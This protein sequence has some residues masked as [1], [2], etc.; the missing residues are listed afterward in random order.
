MFQKMKLLFMGAAI[1]SLGSVH[2]SNF[3]FIGAGAR[4]SG[5]GGA[6][7]AVANDATSIFWNPGGLTHLYEPELS[8][9]GRMDGSSFK[10]PT[11][12]AILTPDAFTGLSVNFAS[13]AYSFKAIGN[14][15]V[16]IAAS[17]S[18]LYDF[19]ANTKLLNNDGSLYLRTDRGKLSQFAVGGAIDVVPG[20]F[21]GTA[22]YWHRGVISIDEKNQG[23]TG[24]TAKT[25][26]SLE[27]NPMLG[28][29]FYWDLSAKWHFGAMGSFRLGALDVI[30]TSGGVPTSSTLG[31]PGSVGVGAAWNPTETI[32]VAMDYRLIQWSGLE[33]NGSRPFY[34]AALTKPE[35]ADAAQLHLGAEYFFPKSPFND[36]PWPWRVGLYTDPS[37]PRSSTGV[38]TNVTFLTIGTSFLTDFGDISM[39]GEFGTRDYGLGI[40]E[41]ATRFIVSVIYRL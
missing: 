9:V 6:F 30:T 12:A 22:L 5:M 29:G 11:A 35:F 16:A 23:A 4:A 26:I 40:E 19:D 18:S 37:G 24:V 1:L 15:H 17:F 10:F 3:G 31:L 28:M 36:F 20:L 32:L 14:R 27:G 25:D 21:F 33:K 13:A 41:T 2:A 38:S 7:I 39:S 34:D 8:F